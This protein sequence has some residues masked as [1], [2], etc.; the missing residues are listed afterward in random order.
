MFHLSDTLIK[1]FHVHIMCHLW[2]RKYDFQNQKSPLTS[3]LRHPSIDTKRH[4]VSNLENYFSRSNSL[5]YKN[6]QCPFGSSPNFHCECQVVVI[7]SRQLYNTPGLPD[8]LWRACHCMLDWHCSL[9]FIT[10]C[11]I[12]Y[13]PGPVPDDFFETMV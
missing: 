9:A 10:L 6:L 11:F 5:T 4:C 8:C 7:L 2:Q 12:C 13:R 1:R 3:Q